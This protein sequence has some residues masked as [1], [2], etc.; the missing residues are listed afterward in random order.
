MSLLIST[1]V[2]L[3]RYIYDIFVMILKFNCDRI[4][5]KILSDIGPVTWWIGAVE[6]T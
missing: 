6:A 4:C 2:P 3:D 5:D 1:P